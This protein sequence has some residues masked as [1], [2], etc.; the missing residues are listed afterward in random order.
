VLKDANNTF[1]DAKEAVP[2]ARDRLVEFLPIEIAF[3]ANVRVQNG[4]S[5]N[6]ETVTPNVTINELFDIMMRLHHMG[7]PV[8][9][10]NNKLVGI[11]TF[12]DAA[13]IRKKERDKVLVGDVCRRKLI[14]INPEE[15]VLD[16]F[17]KMEEHNIGR[18]LVVDRNDPRKLLGILTKHDVM[19]VLTF[20][21]SI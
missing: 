21:R 14:T 18:I 20:C 5:K 10:E 7:Y 12:E 6:V 13:K 9:D 3:L 4:M 15:S 19:H 2:P 1:Q 8:L 17:K 16:A 11:V